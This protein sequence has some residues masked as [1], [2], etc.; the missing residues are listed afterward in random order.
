[1]SRLLTGC[2]SRFQCHLQH[3]GPGG[4]RRK[5]QVLH[6]A[7]QRCH[8]NERRQ[9]QRQRLLPKAPGQHPAARRQWSAQQRMVARCQTEGRGCQCHLARKRLATPQRAQTPPRGAGSAHPEQQTQRHRDGCQMQLVL[10]A[11]AQGLQPLPPHHHR[12]LQPP[13]H[14]GSASLAPESG[15]PMGLQSL[16]GRAHQRCWQLL[17]RQQARQ[18]Q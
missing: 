13:G 6:R 18:G 16:T 5:R 11:C 1:M 12:Q 2:E 3:Q 15:V 9:P 10:A 7:H 4:Y 17:V 8:R 14:V